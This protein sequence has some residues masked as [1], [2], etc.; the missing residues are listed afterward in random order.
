MEASSS[1][2][3]GKKTVGE[4]QK[5]SS[6]SLWASED[7]SCR[8]GIKQDID[9]SR[10]S[11]EWTGATDSQRAI[12]L[13]ASECLV[14]MSNLPWTSLVR[15]AALEDLTAIEDRSLW[16]NQ[17]EEVVLE[18]IK[19][20]LTAEGDELKPYSHS[21]SKHISSET[22]T[23]HKQR[24]SESGFDSHSEDLPPT[25]ITGSIS[26]KHRPFTKP[27]C[28]AEA[29][30]NSESSSHRASDS[31][32]DISKD[33]QKSSV[34]QTSQLQKCPSQSPAA[35][36]SLVPV[37][38]FKGLFAVM[39]TSTEPALLHLTSSTYLIY[40]NAALP[41]CYAALFLQNNF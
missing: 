27:P 18:Q 3:S 24:L 35:R 34:A 25:H 1:P 15:S 17:E 41:L 28:D 23:L 5:R 10:G 31:K 26:E 38:V 40:K 33:L 19:D 2:D 32:P 29:E 39:F 13:D 30:N 4:C 7:L 16:V 12:S 6:E 21:R 36:R 8:S 9:A 11:P 37:A 20:G 22:K 14:E